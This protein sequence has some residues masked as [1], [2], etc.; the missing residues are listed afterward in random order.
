MRPLR[1][2]PDQFEAQLEGAFGLVPRL[3]ARWRLARHAECRAGLERDAK[4]ARELRRALPQFATP[5]ALPA[6]IGAALDQEGVPP[7][8]A[9]RGLRGRL[10]FAA[11]AAAGLIAGLVLASLPRTGPVQAANWP[12]PL[13]DSHIRSMMGDHLTDVGSSDQ[14]AVKPWLSARLGLSPPVRE[15]EGFPLAGGRLDYLQGHDVAAVVYRRRQHVIN[16]FA[17]PTS[18]A[19]APMTETSDRG[20]NVFQWRRDGLALAAVSDLNPAELREFVAH[21]VPLR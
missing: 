19:D 9:T 15:I 12:Q 14:H 17:W 1:H 18:D 20:F 4:A 5:V 8:L 16:L 2:N 3:L 11:T 6:R 7:G 10:P 21:F 13:L